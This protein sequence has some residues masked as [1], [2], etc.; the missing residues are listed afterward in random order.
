MGCILIFVCC[1]RCFTAEPQVEADTPGGYHVSAT[2]LH[3][4][5]ARDPEELIVAATAVLPPPHGRQQ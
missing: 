2:V 4:A 1:P 3:P 5:D